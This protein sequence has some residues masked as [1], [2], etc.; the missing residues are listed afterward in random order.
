MFWKK[1]SNAP[2][3]SE[4]PAAISAVDVAQG[5]VV[6]DDEI[7]AVI[8]AA[9]AAYSERPASGLYIRKINR[10]KGT[11]TTWIQA[12]LNDSIASRKF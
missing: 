8:T 3:E 2:A 4:A 10:A 11:M 6:E 7:I 9:I 12:G 5:T 1:A